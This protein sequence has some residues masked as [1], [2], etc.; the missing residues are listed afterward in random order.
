MTYQSDVHHRR[1]I[2]LKTYDY[3]QPNTYFVTICSQHRACLFGGIQDGK[4]FLNNPGLMTI[5]WFQKLPIKFLNLQCDEFICMPNHIHL[6]IHITELDTQ[7]C[8][9]THP[10]V[11][12]IK[13]CELPYNDQT[14]TNTNIPTIVQWY[15]TMTTNEYICGVKQN[16]WP[17]FNGKLWQRNYWEHVIRNE[18]ELNQIREYIQTNPI[19]W[20]QDKL[21]TNENI[22]LTSFPKESTR[23]K[24]QN[25][26]EMQNTLGADPRVRPIKKREQLGKAQTNSESKTEVTSSA[27]NPNPNTVG[28]DPRV[29]PVVCTGTSYFEWVFPIP[30]CLRFLI[31]RTRGS[32]P[33]E[34]SPQTT[35]V[36]SS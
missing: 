9:G 1:S 6:I 23:Q 15:K 26:M 8:V 13:K 12:P 2:R 25:P 35:E 27:S 19:S 36:L 4:M 31:G 7:L 20:E 21:F 11:R 10:R 33:T 5:K 17:S 34:T 3:S 14:N 22:G 24:T 30:G 29:C 28:A 16:G 18:N 32:A